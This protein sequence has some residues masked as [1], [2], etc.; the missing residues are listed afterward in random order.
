MAVPLQIHIAHHTSH[1]HLIHRLTT[2]LMVLSTI[3]IRTLNE[4]PSAFCG[5]FLRRK[6]IMTL[7][8][9]AQNWTLKAMVAFHNLYLFVV[10]W[11]THRGIYCYCF[12][13]G[14]FHTRSEHFVCFPL[15]L[16]LNFDVDPIDSKIVKQRR[17][18]ITHIHTRHT[19][20]K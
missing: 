19:E 10:W 14:F 11:S 6:N 8:A 20:E 5:L 4:L 17:A 18:I 9:L 16:L 3:V 1:A 15:Q 7:H 13:F 2:F 12:L